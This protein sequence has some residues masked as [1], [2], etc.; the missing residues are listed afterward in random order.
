[1]KC[2][3]HGSNGSILFNIYMIN[4]TIHC[5][6]ALLAVRHKNHHQFDISREY[7]FFVGH[8]ISKCPENR[9]F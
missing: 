3:G 1:M 5:L 2:Y 6:H 7:A 4:N 8:V 9:T